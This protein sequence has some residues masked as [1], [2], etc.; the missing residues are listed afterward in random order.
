[1]P[2][3]SWAAVRPSISD[4]IGEATGFW[5]TERRGAVAQRVSVPDSVLLFFSTLL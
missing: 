1:M 3:S 5:E 4:A 2:R